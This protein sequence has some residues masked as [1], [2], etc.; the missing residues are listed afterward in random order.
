MKKK[1]WITLGVLVLLLVGAYVYF[2]HF[3]YRFTE[4][5]KDKVY[6]SGVIP[7]EKIEKFVDK[8]KIKTIIDLRA[9]WIQDELNPAVEGEINEEHEAVEKI[10]G[11]KH[12]NIPSL[13]IP[14]DS[15]VNK[16]LEVMQD[17]S[18]YPVLIHCYHGTGR[19][20]LFSALYRME[21]EDYSAEEARK[22]SRYIVPFSNF[23]KNS[24]KVKYLLNYEKKLPPKD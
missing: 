20:V 6:S 16:F 24:P 9:G 18:N 15:T 2:V 13:Q 19:A 23:D 8:N 12:I 10:E 4:I 17:S 22:N 14:G 3:Q 1:I 11:V 7:P 5:S 21:F